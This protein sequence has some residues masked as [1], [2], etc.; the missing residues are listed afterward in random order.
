[1]NILSPKNHPAKIL[2][3]ISVGQICLVASKSTIKEARKILRYPKMVKILKKQGFSPEEAEGAF[4]KLIK[5]AVIT[6]GKTKMWGR[7]SIINCL[8]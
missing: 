8:F 1:M 4:N 3:L 6:A 7:I 2:E 5:L